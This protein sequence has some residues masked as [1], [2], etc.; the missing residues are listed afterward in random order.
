MAHAVLLLP[1][2]VKRIR[3]PDSDGTLQNQGDDQQQIEDVP[4]H[5][6]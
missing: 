1:A 6:S 2:I 5:H 4:A 3:R